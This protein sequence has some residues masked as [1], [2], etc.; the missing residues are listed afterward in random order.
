MKSTGP[1]ISE[2]TRG[3]IPRIP[4]VASLPF[5]LIIQHGLEGIF[6]CGDIIKPSPVYRNLG[7]LEEEPTCQEK[8]R[9]GGDHDGITGDVTRHK[10]TNE[11]DISIGGD[12]GSVEDYPKP[13]EAALEVKH[14]LRYERKSE[15]LNR[16]EGE[17]DDE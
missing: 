3:E 1:Q 2:S 11:H 15:A 14:V 12:K 13:E 7:S 10:S 6:D 17:I 9:G 4:T 16:E 5:E 8:Q